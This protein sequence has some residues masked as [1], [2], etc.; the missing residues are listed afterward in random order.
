M[1]RYEKLKNKECSFC[2]RKAEHSFK[3]Q[4]RTTRY[5]YVCKVHFVCGCGAEAVDRHQGKFKCRR[6]LIMSIP[7]EP[8]YPS[9]FSILS[10]AA[11]N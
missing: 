11:E 9:R 6:C 5:I 10:T 4:N 7:P 1:S 2:Y 3:I 8:Q